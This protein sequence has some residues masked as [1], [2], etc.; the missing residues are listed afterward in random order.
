MEQMKRGAVAVF[1][2]EAP[3]RSLGRGNAELFYSFAS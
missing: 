3:I 1:H 2:W